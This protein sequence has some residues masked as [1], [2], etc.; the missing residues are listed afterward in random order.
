MIAAAFTDHLAI[1]LRVN[2]AF[3]FTQRSWKLAHESLIDRIEIFRGRYQWPGL[4]G[5]DM[6]TATLTLYIGWSTMLNER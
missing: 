6:C 5:K 4:S 2:L 1:L 3:S